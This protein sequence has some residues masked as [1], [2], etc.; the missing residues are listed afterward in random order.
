M[1]LNAQEGVRREKK[2]LTA[3]ALQKKRE[4]L[5]ENVE[6]GTCTLL[7]GL[8]IIKM[9]KEKDMERVRVSRSYGNK[10]IGKSSG[11]TPV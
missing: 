11:L 8:K 2:V 9:G 6:T 1:Q 3:L 4:R 7:E 5:S 10:C